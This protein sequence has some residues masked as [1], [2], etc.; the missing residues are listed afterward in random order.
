MRGRRGEKKE[1][2]ANMAFSFTFR[3][4][5]RKRSACSPGEMLRDVEGAF[6]LIWIMSCHVQRGYY[7][8]AMF[9]T[10]LCN[11]IYGIRHTQRRQHGSAEVFVTRS[12]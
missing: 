9:G 8:L 12:R 11:G 2:T 3:Y 10:W 4:E 6:S 7:N 5:K 1:K